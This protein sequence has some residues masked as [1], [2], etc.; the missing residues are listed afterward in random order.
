MG[1]RES[2]KGM[3]EG[4]KRRNRGMK[5]GSGNGRRFR[6]MNLLG[7]MNRKKPIEIRFSSRREANST[8]FLAHVRT[9]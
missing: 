1:Q 3:K 8:I 7:E 6:G 4:D 9:D 2:K 5:E